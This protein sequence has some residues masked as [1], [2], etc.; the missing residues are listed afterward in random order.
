[1]KCHDRVRVKLMANVEN[2]LRGC[3]CPDNFYEGIQPEIRGVFHE[4]DAA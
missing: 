3:M 4:R 1:M 2:W